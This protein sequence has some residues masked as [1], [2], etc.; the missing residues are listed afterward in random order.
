MEL[1]EQVT[2][3]LH[4]LRPMLQQFAAVC[5]ISADI[6]MKK[7]FLERLIDASSDSDS[8]TDN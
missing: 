2:T 5:R 7:L 4:E 3:M 6:Y 1:E 8:T